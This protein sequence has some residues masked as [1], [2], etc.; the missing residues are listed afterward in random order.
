MDTSSIAIF[1]AMTGKMRELQAK[2]EVIA[3]NIANA[4]TPGY[5]ARV[6]VEKDFSDILANVSNTSGTPKIAK[7]HINVPAAMSAL[8]SSAAVQNNTEASRDVFEVKPNGNTVVLEDQLLSL[9]NVQME[10]TA[11][12]NL[13]RKQAGLLKTA[14]GKGGN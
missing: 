2:Q 10:Y 5:E 14:I 11:L 6:L 13:Y 1:Q 4:D 12:T 8:G 3:Q 9:A 7:P